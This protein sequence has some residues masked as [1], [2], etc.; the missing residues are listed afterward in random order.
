M[1][2]PSIEPDFR[3]YRII[4]ERTVSLHVFGEN[5]TFHSAYSPKTH[6][7]ASSLN[8]LCTAESAQFNFTFLPTTISLTPRFRWKRQVWLRF[9]AENAQNNPKT[10]SYEDNTKFNSLFLATMLSNA[11]RFWRKQGVI[12]YFEY[13]G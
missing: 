12:E 11:S 7:L 13:L 3:E 9:F 6:N 10:H 8:T 2:N 5:T 1:L 4:T